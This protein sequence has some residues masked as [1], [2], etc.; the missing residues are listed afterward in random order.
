MLSGIVEKRNNKAKLI[1]GS[2][3]I[4]NEKDRQK[5]IDL[6]RGTIIAGND[7]MKI[8]NELE[9]LTNQEINTNNKIPDDLFND[10]K[11]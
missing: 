6:P 3:I 4:L 9:Q 8:Y 1:N 7:N 2:A 10:L 5:T 11:I